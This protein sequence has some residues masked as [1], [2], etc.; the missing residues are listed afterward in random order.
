M[1]VIYGNN[2]KETWKRS[3]TENRVKKDFERTEDA[4]RGSSVDVESETQD[5]DPIP[6]Q[7]GKGGGA[8]SPLTHLQDA[9]VAESALQ[10]CRVH[11]CRDVDGATELSRQG[12]PVTHL[13][14]V[15]V[16]S[17]TV[18]DSVNVCHSNMQSLPFCPSVNRFL[19]TEI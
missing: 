1:Q 2:T 4:E 19:K 5:L 10:C 6:A 7:E 12:A 14:A 13:G 16:L 15:S 11:V 8:S 9:V 3:H 18:R 17:F